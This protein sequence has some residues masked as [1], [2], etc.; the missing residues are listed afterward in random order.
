[1]GER[2]SNTLMNNTNIAKYTRVSFNLFLSYVNNIART[3]SIDS[4]NLNIKILKSPT[5]GGFS[6]LT[7][8][9]KPFTS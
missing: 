8:S 2:L 3:T 7:A 6:D 9:R 4:Y 1:M 5:S